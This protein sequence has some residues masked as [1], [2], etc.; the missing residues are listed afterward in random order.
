M[1]NN[2]IYQK[3]NTFSEKSG[4]VLSHLCHLFQVPGFME[5]SWILIATAALN[6]CNTL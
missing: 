3:Q 1:K 4:A 2:Y 6:L 5:G